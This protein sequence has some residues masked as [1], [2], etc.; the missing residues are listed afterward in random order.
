[1][2]YLQ[3]ARGHFTDS[4]RVL[5]PIQL[6]EG[7]VFS[8]H[9]AIATTGHTGGDMVTKPQDLQPLSGPRTLSC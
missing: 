8:L 6:R 5:G 7:L 1:M 2:S 4:P 9:G 3:S